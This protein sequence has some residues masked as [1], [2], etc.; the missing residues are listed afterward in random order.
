MSRPALATVTIL[1]FLASW[2]SYVWPLVV[3]TRQS[4]RTLPLGLS[5]FF[6]EYSSDYGQALAASIMIMLPV[7]IVFIIL[8][9]QFVEGLARVGL[10]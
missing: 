7:L 10:K 2:D 8:Q 6:S 4:M 1:S 9:R 3:V 5:M